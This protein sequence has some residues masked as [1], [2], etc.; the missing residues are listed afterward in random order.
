[1]LGIETLEEQGLEKL[2]CVQGHHKSYACAQGRTHPQMRPEKTI[3]F[4]FTGVKSKAKL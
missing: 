3:C 2:L 1:M 4:H